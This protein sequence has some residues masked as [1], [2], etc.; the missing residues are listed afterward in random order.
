MGNTGM[1]M[2]DLP[3][4]QIPDTA[5][6]S[7]VAADLSIFV[8]FLSLAIAL[9]LRFSPAWS[10]RTIDDQAAQGHIVWIIGVTTVLANL[11]APLRSKSRNSGNVSAFSSALAQAFVAAYFIYAFA[12]VF[13][14]TPMQIASHFPAGSKELIA[15][16][17]AALVV[18]LLA[19]SLVLSFLQAAA[20]QLFA[21]NSSRN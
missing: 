11:L 8:G 7:T 17:Y 15:Y 20:A 19:P 9:P 16:S 2:P 14:G 21:R 13:S 10:V 4:R 12:R 6:V 5:V 3:G 1:L 18:S